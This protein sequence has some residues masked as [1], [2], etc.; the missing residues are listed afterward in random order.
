MNGSW[1]IWKPFGLQSLFQPQCC[2]NNDTQMR[3]KQ[4][5]FCTCSIAGESATITWVWQKHKAD[6]GVGKLYV[7][8]NRQAGI[9]RLEAGCWP[10]KVGG[11]QLE[12]DVIGYR[13]VFYFL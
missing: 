11:S 13:C 1:M 10:G 5:L 2:G 6:R 8:A 7:V 12:A 3:K 9:L 4:T